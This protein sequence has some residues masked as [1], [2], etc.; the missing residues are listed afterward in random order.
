MTDGLSQLVKTLPLV[1]P[2][3]SQ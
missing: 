2:F 3:F 1:E